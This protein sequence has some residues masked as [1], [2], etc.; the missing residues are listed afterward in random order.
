MKKKVR[1]STQQNSNIC[2]SVIIVSYK[3]EKVLLKCL[4]ALQ[5]V[6]DHDNVSTEVLVVDN[7][8]RSQLKKIIP[9]NFPNL[10]YIHPDKN[11]GFGAGNNLG[12]HQAE[13]KYLLFLNPDTEIQPGA[14]QHLVSFFQKHLQAAVV[15]PTLY[16]MKGNRYSDQG[17]QL[18]TPLTALASHSILHTIWPNNPVANA[19][20]ARN[21]DV[22]M[23]QQLAAVPG[24]ALMIRRSFFQKIHGFD[25]AFFLYFEEVDLCRRV[26]QLQGK[27]WQIPDATVKHIWGATTHNTRTQH[28]FEESRHTYF[29]KYY[30][31][32]V[33][34]FVETGLRTG[35]KQILLLGGLFFLLMCFALLH[36]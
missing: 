24:T 29:Q 10:K 9:K 22:K 27:I 15:A 16:D 30:G 20:W 26:E 21:R 33:A 23:P 35:K 1:A 36:R 31:T 6:I 3:A 32:V 19:F 13:G 14:L 4:S 28:I 25:E 5:Q 7:Y 11:L 17:S 8:P 2:V 18:L 12:A 34:T